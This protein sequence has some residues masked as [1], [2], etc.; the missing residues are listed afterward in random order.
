MT[1]WGKRIL[2]RR[3]G[4]DEALV[5]ECALQGQGVAKRTGLEHDALGQSGGS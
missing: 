4:K 5:G 2:G 3:N 1:I